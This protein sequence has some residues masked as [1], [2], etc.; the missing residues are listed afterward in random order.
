MR[1]IPEKFRT[2][3]PLKIIKSRI[4]FYNIRSLEIYSCSTVTINVKRAHEDFHADKIYKLLKVL[5]KCLIRFS[6]CFQK[7]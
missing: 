5:E 2:V 6:I 3:H 4:K 7:I 1:A